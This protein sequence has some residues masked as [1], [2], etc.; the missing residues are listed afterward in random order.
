MSNEF[1]SIKKL[2]VNYR[3]IIIFTR[4]GGILRPKIKL[5]SVRSIEGPEKHIKSKA[6]GS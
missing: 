1:N 3:I 5:A 2:N 4:Y 6:V